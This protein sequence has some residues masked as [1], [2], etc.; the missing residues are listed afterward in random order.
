MW[1]TRLR[2]VSE[3]LRQR[4]GVIYRDIAK[5]IGVSIQRAREV[6]LQGLRDEGLSLD[7]AWGERSRLGWRGPSD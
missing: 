7:E 2:P 5:A 6:V 1:P 4:Q 3:E